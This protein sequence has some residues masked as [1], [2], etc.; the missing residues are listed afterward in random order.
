E[1]MHIRLIF[2]NDIKPGNMGLNEFLQLV[3]YDFAQSRLRSHAYSDRF[4]DP[5]SEHL[6]DLRSLALSIIQIRF[7][8]AIEVLTRDVRALGRRLIERSDIEGPEYR[9]Y[10]IA[11]GISTTAGWSKRLLTSLPTGDLPELLDWLRAFDFLRSEG[12]AE[13]NKDSYS[14]LT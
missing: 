7:R 2:A 8:D 3:L 13:L 12:V 5:G 11:D 10:L 1:W 6:K 4:H 9:R 14:H